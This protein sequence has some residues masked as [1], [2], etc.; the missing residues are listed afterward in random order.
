[1]RAQK[2]K[3]KLTFTKACICFKLNS[4]G[5]RTCDFFLQNE[6]MILW[7]FGKRNKFEQ[8]GHELVCLNYWF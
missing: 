2:N 7:T 4:T 5:I 3:I 8:C 6:L 1:M